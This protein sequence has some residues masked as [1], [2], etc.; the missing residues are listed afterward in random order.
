MALEMVAELVTWN[1]ESRV[2]VFL[3]FDGAWFAAARSVG[4]QISS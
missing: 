4:K 3:P 2:F 1:I